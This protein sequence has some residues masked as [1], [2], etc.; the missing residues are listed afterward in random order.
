MLASLMKYRAYGTTGLLIGSVWLLLTFALTLE[1]VYAQKK[2]SSSRGTNTIVLEKKVEEAEA[3]FMKTAADVARDYE[4]MGELE[5]AQDV[6]KKIL[7]LQPGLKK[8]RDKIKELEEAR[9]ATNEV[10]LDID[11]GKGWIVTG[12]AVKK[13]NKIRFLSDGECRILISQR[14]GTDGFPSGDVKQDLAVGVPLG[15]LMG[16]IVNGT[17]KGKGKGKTR[18]G[19]PFLI[20]KKSEIAASQDGQL[21]V[22]MNVPPGSKCTG[23][24][25]L[26]ISGDILTPKSSSG[27]K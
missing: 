19:T 2:S 11:P 23:R 5:K 25:R 18:P 1:T 22:R 4:E 17:A 20:G 26:K 9:L 27:G 8:V 6:L 14:I 7:S 15:A 10:T 3:S 13:G 16:V 21:L 12:V 24:I